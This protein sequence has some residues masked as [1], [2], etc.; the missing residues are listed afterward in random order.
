M[1]TRL[2]LTKYE[3]AQGAAFASANDGG[4]V[5]QISECF[6]ICDVRI[7]S[8]ATRQCITEKKVFNVTA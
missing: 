3:R 1:G 5:L 4:D 7:P 6:E 2:F 8:G